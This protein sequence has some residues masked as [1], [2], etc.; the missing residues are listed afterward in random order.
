MTQFVELFNEFLI[1]KITVL[2][3]LGILFLCLGSFLNVLIYRL[4]INESLVKK[5]SHCP[6]C[7][8]ILKWYENI[9]LISYIIQQGRCRGCKCRISVRYPII[10]S[11]AVVM[12]I[13]SYL[14][15]G[16][17]YE[18]LI[19]TLLLLIFIVIFCIDI[20]HYIIP[21]SMNICIFVLGLLLI[22]F[23]HSSINNQMSIN[24]IDKLIGLGVAI[25]IFILT[26]V[27]EKIVKKELIGGG[28]LK[29]FLG[30]GL[31]MGWQ[32]LLLGIF[33]SSL[34]G[35]VFEF[36]KKITKNDKFLNKVIPFGP[37]LTIG[38]SLSYFFGLDL[39]NLY[40]SFFI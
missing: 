13:I 32:L 18:M 1:L 3:I 8:H 12:F 24:Y 14:R 39:I 20:K 23:P 17:T 2:L 31:L 35:L 21:D 29:L 26:Y 25:I 11:L 40:F 27:L 6:K 37:Y 36:I 5:N 7:N 34:I 30:I 38:F 15:F 16:L 28:D 4:P 33:I 10:E 22:F 19:V 9:P